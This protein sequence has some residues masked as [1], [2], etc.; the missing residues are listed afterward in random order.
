MAAG[1]ALSSL[2]RRERS[3]PA[4][5]RA[6]ELLEERAPVV[7]AANVRDAGGSSGSRLD[8]G[9]LDRLR[10]DESRLAT[11]ARQLEATAALEPL[12][13]EIASR[14]LANGLGGARAAHPRRRRLGR[15]SRRGPGVAL[16]IAAQVLKSLN[17]I[18]LRTGGAAL[19]TVE[20]ARRR[21][22]AARARGR[23]GIAGAV[24]LVRSPDRD[25]ARGARVTASR[26]PLVILR[27]SGD[28]TAALARLA[29][30]H[31][32]RTLAHAEGGGVL[33]VHASAR[34]DR[35][36]AIVDASLDRLG[37]CNRLNLALVDSD[38]H[39]QAVAVVPPA[40]DA[41]SSWLAPLVQRLFSRSLSWT[42][43][44][45]TSRRTIRSASPR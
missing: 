42:N 43:A 6:A 29:A 8:E 33:Y 28:T 5:R 4:L 20:D 41:V 31:G 45:A 30:E 17:A 27:G 40:R 18:V 13:R 15:I 32:V 9:A 26:I 39:A 21:G 22:A 14:T 16:D 1:G 37:V 3:G 35:V 2:G 19:R 12:E 44:S 23:A 24:G 11:L 38:A 36:M 25:G 34:S 7:L 10:L